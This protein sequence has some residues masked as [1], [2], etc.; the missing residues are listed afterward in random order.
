LSDADRFAAVMAQALIDKDGINAAQIAASMDAERSALGDPDGA[1]I[2][3]DVKREIERLQAVGYQ[4]R[5]RA[6][7]ALA[8][9]ALFA[10]TI[11][12]AAAM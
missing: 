6:K 9:P 10:S 12:D 1:H 4:P 11:L 8:R 5:R 3:R 2:W 7:H